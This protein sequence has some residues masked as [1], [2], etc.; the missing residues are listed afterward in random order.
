MS[1]AT[2][3]PSSFA[4]A[5]LI[6]TMIS[7]LSLQ[8]QNI[9]TTIQEGRV[10]IN[11]TVQYGDSN[12]NATYQSGMV[13]INRTIQVGGDNRNQTGQFGWV[14]HNRTSQRGALGSAWSKR[15]GDGRRNLS[16]HRSKQ[17]D[18]KRSGDRP[19]RKKGYRR[20]GRD[21]D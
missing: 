4:V 9:N 8:A 12:D 19:K 18:G 6:A 13:N 21:D 3:K 2:T 1:I 7:P 10:N 20:E 5:A 11:R 15:G 16:S 17:D 14:N